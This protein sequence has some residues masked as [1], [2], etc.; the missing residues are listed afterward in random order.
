[1]KIDTLGYL[2]RTTS[3]GISRNW[4]LGNLTGIKFSNMT[5]SI[6]PELVGKHI[7]FRVEVED[8]E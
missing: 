4:W 2:S 5:L 6:P 7:R 8:A 1:M 3:K